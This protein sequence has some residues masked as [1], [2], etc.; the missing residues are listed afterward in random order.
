M[1]EMLVNDIRCICVLGILLFTGIGTIQE[2]FLTVY[3]RIRHIYLW[4]DIRYRQLV[5]A[6]FTVFSTTVVLY[7]FDDMQKILTAGTMAEGWFEIGTLPGRI[8]GAICIITGIFL[9]VYNYVIF[10]KGIAKSEKQTRQILAEIVPLNV[11]ALCLILGTAFAGCGLYVADIIFER[12]AL[13]ES[14]GVGGIIRAGLCMAAVVY[15]FFDARLAKE[16]IINLKKL[17]YSTEERRPVTNVW[18]AEEKK[19]KEQKLDDLYYIIGRCGILDRLRRYGL[20]KW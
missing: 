12:T 13:D 6:F 20:W 4:T 17:K 1:N 3:R 11:M 9:F 7:T 10:G 8:Y 2:G 14:Y 19:T 15:M 18:D 16:K 5:M